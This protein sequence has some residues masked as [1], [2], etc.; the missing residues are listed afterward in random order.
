MLI[1][2]YDGLF[3]IFSLAVSNQVTAGVYSVSADFN[4]P[5]FYQDKLVISLYLPDILHDIE[6]TGLPSGSGY[7]AI[8]LQTRTTCSK[9]PYKQRN[10]EHEKVSPMKHFQD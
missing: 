7:T 10:R 6:L 1:G 4:L 9:E 3:M 2:H 5:I 8:L